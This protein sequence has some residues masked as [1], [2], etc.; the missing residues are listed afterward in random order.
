MVGSA[1]FFVLG[2]LSAFLLALL[3]AP[4]VWRRAVYLTQKRIESAVPLT[5]NELQ[6][7][8]DRL[9]AEHAVTLKKVDSNLKD[10]RDRN[11]KLAAELADLQAQVRSLD[12]R[13]EAREATI[14]QLRNT[15]A[16]TEGHLLAK[17]D[18]LDV[19]TAENRAMSA[20]LSARVS[21]LELVSRARD[22]FDTKASV[23]GEKLT[24]AVAT[25]ATLRAAL[26]AAK[27][28]RRD[29]QAKAREARRSVSESSQM[30]KSEHKRAEALDER[31][32]KAI[33]R[34][35][36]LEEKLTRR[37]KEIA[38]LRDERSGEL[39]EIDEMER[40]AIDAED[41]R[42]ALERELADL[43]LRLNQMTA[44][45]ELVP[46]VDD[47]ASKKR[48]AALEAELGKA[49]AARDTALA[50]AVQANT[51]AMQTAEIGDHSAGS[52]EG[53]AALRDEMNT[54]AAHVLHMASMLEGEGSEVAAII[55]Q[56]DPS[57]DGATD[58]SVESLSLADRVRV[59]QARAAANKA[60]RGKVSASKH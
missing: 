25:E 38:R 26:D 4:A 32:Q 33:S 37:E 58:D 18:E 10:Q 22:E 29:D 49:K 3:I 42:Q 11:T 39:A 43:T 27:E 36:D 19:L 28:R 1:V 8:K 60:R 41:E 53:D 2:A 35:S 47:G 9:R 46:Q 52:A 59:L 7:D 45:S 20:D 56:P 17:S 6:A 44:A 31:L 24:A 54:L 55:N 23:L 14:V 21:E 13:L 40:R 16:E 57:I 34:A 48:I 51:H 5:V 12:E 15:L 30:A 50:A